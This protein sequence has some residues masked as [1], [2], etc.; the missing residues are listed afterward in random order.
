MTIQRKIV[1]GYGLVMG[2][3][4]GG[5]FIGLAIGNHY[6]QQAFAFNQAATSE[7]RL[8]SELQVQVL[9]NRPTRQL[10]P[11]LDDPIAFRR[12][13]TAFL[14]RLRD[15]HAQLMN[16]HDLP[17]HQK[18]MEDGEPLHSTESGQH[19]SEKL[20]DFLFDYEETVDTFIQKFEAFLTQITPLIT[21]SE[22][23]TLVQ[24][25]LLDLA[26]SSEF[27]TFIEF[28]DR[29]E[30][31]YAKVRQLEQRSEA[32]LVVAERLR[33]QI[34]LLS[35]GLSGA[36]ATAIAF[37]TSRNISRPLKAA[38]RVARQ[39][40][41]NENF[42]L[43][44]PIIS[45]DETGILAHALNKLIRQVKTLLIR[46]EDKN[47]DL[48]EALDNLNQKQVQLI[49]AEKMSSLGQLVAGVAHEINNPVNF[50]HGNL[51][52]V[53]SHAQDMLDYLDALEV[54]VPPGQT[55]VETLAE[56][57]DLDFLREDL[58]KALNSMEHGTERIRQ[59]VLSLRNFSRLDEANFKAV[60]LH[61]GLESALVIL[62][63]RLKQTSGQCAIQ[64]TKNYGDL[65]LV[66]CYPS[67][68]N[69]VFINIL[70]NA[71]DALEERETQQS[72]AGEVI[73]PKRI[74]LC[75]RKIDNDWVEVAISDNGPGIPAEAQAKILDPFFTT[76]PIGKGT[77]LG[78]SISHQIV[79]E[80]HRGQLKFTSSEQ[81]TE[82]CILIPVLSQKGD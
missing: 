76:K 5:T 63:H 30:P 34:I 28:T 61:E 27:S 33:S 6:Q 55:E 37:L 17:P 49:Q 68:L 70:A 46:L 77:G 51:T 7:R 32:A 80:K 65:P 79:A 22:N 40:T 10:S 82:F 35:L 3:A 75:T 8:L 45:Q 62:H 2:V 11:Y 14:K 53:K 20:H 16:H 67:Q 43:Q 31:F 15:L 39:V 12:E 26:A 19:L 1:L 36:M 54:H 13:S 21:S 25:L 69:Q 23:P 24:G 64:I 71:I 48:Q 81:G 60:N 57:I 41:D 38:T 18:A 73:T 29:L 9:Y 47:T 72:Q 42:N 52:H 66:H 58:T 56:D 59:L 50:I 4:F 44:V 74:T 78:M